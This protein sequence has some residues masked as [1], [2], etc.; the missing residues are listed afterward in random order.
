MGHL[1]MVGC[2]RGRLRGGNPLD[3]PAQPLQ[4]CRR[5]A[6]EPSALPCG[7]ACCLR[8]LQ[9]HTAGCSK[10][11]SSAWL[12]HAP[13]AKQYVSTAA[14]QADVFVQRAGLAGGLP[15]PAARTLK[16][17]RFLATAVAEDPHEASMAVATCGGMEA[18]L[19]LGPTV[20]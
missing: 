17:L 3:K 10:L 14:H 18:A 11:R 13:A 7:C 4:G 5:G 20:C 9:P 15:G 12:L 8:A 19:R 1:P 6:H 2:S 16:D